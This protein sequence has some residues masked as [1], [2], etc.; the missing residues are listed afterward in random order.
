MLGE[1]VV[2]KSGSSIRERAVERGCT[3][4]VSAARERE[5]CGD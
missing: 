5:G 1:L 4:W 3:A 2:V